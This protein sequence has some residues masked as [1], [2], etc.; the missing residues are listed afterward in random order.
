MRVTDHYPVQWRLPSLY[1][2]SSIEF[3]LKRIHSFV[4]N[5]IFNLKQKFFFT[6]SEQMRHQ[7]IEFILVYEAFLVTLQEKDATYHMTKTTSYLENLMKKR[8][9][10]LGH[11][12]STRAEKYA[13]FLEPLEKAF[14]GK[15]NSNSRVSRWAKPSS[16]NQCRCHDWTCLSILLGGLQRKGNPLSESRSDWIQEKSGWKTSWTSIKTVRVQHQW[17][18]SVHSSTEN[19]NIEWSREGVEQTAQIDSSLTLRLHSP[20]NSM[21][22]SSRTPIQSIENCRRW[23][24]DRK[25]DQRLSL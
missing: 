24:S 8:R 2:H 18:A 10:I 14:Q 11:Y 22:Y 25:R 13:A 20:K 19:E 16:D 12:L 1:S 23:S 17:S 9:S 15:S 5:C 6:L 21:S 4:F 3:E 7:S